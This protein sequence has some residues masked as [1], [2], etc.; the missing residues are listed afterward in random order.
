MIQIEDMK[1]KKPNLCT[2]NSNPLVLSPNVTQA[3][4][5]KVNFKVG[6]PV[7]V[8][9]QSVYNDEAFALCILI[10]PRLTVIVGVTSDVF[11]I[12][13]V[14]LRT[15]FTCWITSVTLCTGEFFLF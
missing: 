5:V 10:T 9:R 8:N 12:A 7:T 1:A 13:A 2:L 14:T 6:L 11:G 4:E 15:Q 3:V